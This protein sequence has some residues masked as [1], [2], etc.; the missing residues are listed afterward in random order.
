MR[1]MLILALLL[2]APAGYAQTDP[3][4]WVGATTVAYDGG[5]NGLGFVGLNA[6]TS[7]GLARIIREEVS[8]L[9]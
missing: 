3:Y 2:V 8:L 7:E 4:Q 9:N 5:G 6:S 1:W